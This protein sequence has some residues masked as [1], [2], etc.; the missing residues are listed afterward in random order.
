M[1]I[2][3]AICTR[4]SV[5]KYKN[6]PI[7]PEKIEKIRLFINECNRESGLHIQLVTDEPLAFSTGLFKYGQFSGVKNYLALVAPKQGKWKET[8]GFYG[9]KIVLFMQTLGLNTCWVALTYKNI[10]NAYEL[11][12]GEELKMVIAC[13]YG[14]TNGVQH[15]QKKSVSDFFSD[16]RTDKKE[17]LPTWFVQGMEAALMAPTAM[18]Q[19]KFLFTLLDNNKVRATAKF[20]L[21]GNAIFDLGIV[22]YNFELAAGKENFQWV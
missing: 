22:K 16:E 10:K 19:Q 8:V 20:D 13:G 18:N 1:D 15:P 3:D 6:L 2:K 17:S 11:L 9:Q 21:F 4:H 7:E 12:P 5:R 14:E